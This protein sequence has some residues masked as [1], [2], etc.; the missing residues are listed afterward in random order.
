[1]LSE[2]GREAFFPHGGILG[3][4]A[5]AKGKRYNATIGIALEE[6]GSPMRLPCMT[7]EIDVRPKDMFPYASSFGKPELRTLW[8]QMIRDKNP[9]LKAPITVPVVTA[10]LTHGLTV[11]GYLFIDPGDEVIL[12][13]HF[14]GN[15]KLTFGQQ[16]GAR[17]NTFST[18]TTDGYFSVDNLRTALIEGAPRKRI[19]LLNFPN[20]PTGYTPTKEE[21][22]EITQVLIESADAGNQLV[23]LIDDAYFGLVY[24]DGVER[25]SLFAKL[26][27]AHQHILAVKIDGATKEDYAWGFR[28]G[29]LTYG[30]KGMTPEVAAVLEDKTAGAVRGTVSN[31]C[32]LS[33]SLLI[34]AYSNIDYWRQ[35][36]EK[37]ALL[38]RR[39]ETVK[40]CVADEKYTRYFRPL[41]F[42][43]GYFMCIELCDE[44]DAQTVR[45]TLLDTFDTGV[46]ATGNLLR[47][48][49]SSLPTDDIAPLFANIY[50]ACVSLT[51][52]HH[53]PV[54]A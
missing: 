28:I 4:T 40:H 51:Q 29:F 49:Y 39:Y 42:N 48:A 25:E 17:L 7:E 14:W 53:E 31:C 24:E 6:D 18:F 9:S 2:R 37:S 46:I 19:V 12:T 10:A 52:P 45:Q 44:L 15:Y 34:E 33:Q 3:Q 5:E 41:P 20:N 43:S 26:A 21:A 11:A 47:I 54:H 35:K 30:I 23:V 32:H 13:N 38:R 50:H 22:R 16:F 27:D 8:Q 36:E 1:M